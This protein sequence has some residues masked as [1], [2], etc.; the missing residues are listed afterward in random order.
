MYLSKNITVIDTTSNT[1][2][3]PIPVGNSQ[4][5]IAFDPVHHRMYVTIANYS[6]TVSVINTNNNSV[7]GSPIHVGS[8]PWGIAF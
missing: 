3:L 5:G 2:G 6:N 7:V 4:Q 8:N 1:V